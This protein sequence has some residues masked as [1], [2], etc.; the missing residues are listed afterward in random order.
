MP[1]KNADGRTEKG[2]MLYLYPLP[3][4]CLK[5]RLSFCLRSVSKKN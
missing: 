1:G 4:K 3:K 5:T 2:R